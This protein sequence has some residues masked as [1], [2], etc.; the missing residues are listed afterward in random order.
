MRDAHKNSSAAA[1]FSGMSWSQISDQMRTLVS[2]QET[3]L[4]HAGDQHDK[5]QQRLQ[6][7]ATLVDAT[8]ALQG[9]LSDSKIERYL[10]QWT[11]AQ[12]TGKT[13]PKPPFDAQE[14]WKQQVAKLMAQGKSEEEAQAMV[15][16]LAQKLGFSVGG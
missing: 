9:T 15:A 14:W 4:A 12:A 7:M 5:L 10:K 11:T 1:A 3:I 6:H 2:K 16:G 8:D 13:A